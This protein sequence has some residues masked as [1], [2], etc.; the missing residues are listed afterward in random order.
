MPK[1]GKLSLERLTTCHPDIQKVM[2][3][4]FVYCWTNRV[5]NTKYVGYHLGRLNDGYVSSSKSQRFWD[6]YN[7][8]LLERTIIHTGNKSDCFE[9]EQLILL[10]ANLNSNEWYNNGRGGIVFFTDEIRKKIS[11]AGKRRTYNLEADRNKKI[12]EFRKTYKYSD[13]AKKKIGDSHKGKTVC[14]YVKDAHSA[15]MSGVGNS[16]ATKVICNTTGE[17][18]NLMSEAANRFNVSLSM[19]SQII[20]GKRTHKNGYLFSK[21]GV[22]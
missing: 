12:S 11:D 5:N 8:G 14:Q 4:A 15:R 3:E 9:L 18:F 21:I 16:R 19:M 10:E 6:D 7:L 2:N 22:Q 20:S 13:E 17:V 1:F